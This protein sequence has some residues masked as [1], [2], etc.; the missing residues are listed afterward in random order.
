[1]FRAS[2]GYRLLHRHWP[3]AGSPRGTIVALHGIQS[4][5]GWYRESSA[6]FARAGYEVYFLDRRGS[7]LHAAQ[8]GHAPHEDRLIADVK[9]WLGAWRWE[10][11]HERPRPVILMGVSW[12][13]KLAT[14]CATAFPDELAG[15]ALLYPGLYPKLKPTWW[16]R[17]QLTMA[18]V[19]GWGSASAPIPLNDPTLFTDD[20]AWQEWLR[21]DELALHRVTV[22]FLRAN[23]RLTERIEA[24][25]GR[26][27]CPVLMLLAGRDDIV[28]NVAN[29][30]FVERLP[31]D[32]RTI[33]EYPGARHTLEFERQPHP[34]L[35]DVTRWLDALT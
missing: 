3:T 17:Y 31:A 23:L 16:Q 25:V 22:D 18:S 4:H 9:Q 20:P 32:K 15:L 27:T 6:H 34:F 2:D 8:R 13:G 7:G 26:I 24:N 14:A 11:R 28:D 33:V 29:R 5:G 12:G 10:R 35:G 21:R 19:V 30:R 1:M